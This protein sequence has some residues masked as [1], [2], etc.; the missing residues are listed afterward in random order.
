MTDAFFEAPVLNSPYKY[1]A[2]H[3]EL[4]ETRQPTNLVLELRRPAS[5]ITPV[6]RPRKQRAQTRQGELVLDEGQGL[7]TEDQQYDPTST[8]NVL[9]R[10]VGLWRAS[11]EAQ[12]NVTPETAR[13]VQPRA[14]QR[15]PAGAV[16][17]SAMR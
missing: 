12:W 1:P 9:R 4:D 17:P 15:S 13:L 14:A 7:S 6:P 8:I 16:S 2:L 11:P 5:Y 10:E 3:W